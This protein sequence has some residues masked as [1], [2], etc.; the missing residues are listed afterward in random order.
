MRAP[1]KGKRPVGR[2]KGVPNRF[3]REVKE[4]ILDAFERVGGVEWLVALAMGDPKSFAALLAR[5]LPTQITGENGG[6]VQVVLHKALD[7]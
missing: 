7:A 3:S 4:S 6:P 5:V 1:V 2:V